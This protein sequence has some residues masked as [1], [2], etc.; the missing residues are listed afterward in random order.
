[1]CGRGACTLPP[2]RCV[3]VAGA[4]GF[5][6]AARYRAKCNLTPQSWVPV[7][8]SEGAGDQREVRTMRWGLVPSYAK[9]VEEFGGF[10]GGRPS[11]FNARVESVGQSGMW[12]RLVDQRRCLVMFDGFYEWKQS[13]DGKKKTPMFIRHNPTFKEMTIPGGCSDIDL[14]KA[15]QGSDCE[16]QANLS[17]HFG[18]GLEEGGMPLLLAGLYDVWTPPDG[19]EPLETV[20]ILTMDPMGTPMESIHD[21]MPVFLS[22]QTAPA[23][24]TSS[25]AKVSFEQYVDTVL[26]EA[27]RVAL[28]RLQIYEVADLVG[29]IRNDT[30][31]CLAPRK[32]VAKRQ[33]ESGLG[34]FFAKKPK[35]DPEAPSDSKS[36]EV[37]ATNSSEVRLPLVQSQTQ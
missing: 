14:E 29:N 31:E 1:M 10:G 27:K 2:R 7:V 15:L 22:E 5:R 12:R 33:F 26:K 4:R 35:V 20:T 3:R 11:T 18:A 30:P 36:E 32:E 37:P 13:K 9:S 6:G 17:T 16:A 21:R 34:R 25:S 28:E 23:W 8:V 24:L 19:G